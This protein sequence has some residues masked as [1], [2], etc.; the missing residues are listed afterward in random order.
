M[1]KLPSVP[2]EQS[3]DNIYKPLNWDYSD[4]DV[5]SMQMMPTSQ[6]QISENQ[7]QQQISLSTGG[8]LAQFNNEFILGL[9]PDSSFI[10]PQPRPQSQQLSIPSYSSVISKPNKLNNKLGKLNNSQAHPGKTA[11]VTYTTYTPMPNVMNK[12]TISVNAN[13]NPMQ[14]EAGTSRG[15]K[16]AGP[17]QPNIKFTNTAVGSNEYNLLSSRNLQTQLIPLENRQ[18]IAPLKVIF[19]F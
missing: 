16:F 6:Q 15:Y 18:E 8:K 17:I 7:Y 14:N 19:Y 5:N 13:I 10:Q 4:L 2:E 3:S 9:Q 1:S 11:V 12:E